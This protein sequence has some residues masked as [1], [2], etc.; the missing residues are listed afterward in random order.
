MKAYWG[1][2]VY[3]HSF[4][5]LGTRWRWVVIFTPRPL[6]REG[7]RPWYPFVSFV[8]NVGITL[9]IRVCFLCCLS[10]KSAKE[11]VAYVLYDHGNDLLISM[12]HGSHTITGGTPSSKLIQRQYIWNLHKGSSWISQKSEDHAQNIGFGG[13]CFIPI[14]QSSFSEESSSIKNIWCLCNCGNVTGPSENMLRL[15]I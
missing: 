8:V 13:R 11:R 3:L 4:Y 2:E 9:Y 12:F 10:L 15:G 1:V 14:R 5:D 6:Y 7:K